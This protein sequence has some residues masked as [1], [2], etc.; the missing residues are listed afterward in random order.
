MDIFGNDKEKRLSELQLQPLL[1]SPISNSTC[2][3]EGTFIGVSFHE[4]ELTELLC[5]LGPIVKIESNYGSMISP[6]YI[7]IDK[8]KV[9]NRGRKKKLKPKKH[10][11]IQGDG[12]KFNSCIQFCI[13]GRATREKSQVEDKYSRLAKPLPPKIV[14]SQ[15]GDIEIKME[16][17]I[18][19]YKFKLFRTGVFQV[20]G[21][22]TEDMSDI[23]APLNALEKYLNF[24][25]TSPIKR[26]ILFSVMRNYKFKL[27]NGC[28][29]LRQLHN[30]CIERFIKLSTINMDDLEKFILLP[31][32]KNNNMP[33][34]R[35]EDNWSSIIDMTYNQLS[36]STPE[37]FE[38][39]VMEMFEYL[40]MSIN[41]HNIYVDKDKLM[42]WIVEA[43]F[44]IYY[45][46]FINYMKI[47]RDCYLQVS[48]E[49]SLKILKLLLRNPIGEL[50]KNIIKHPDNELADI[51][52]DQEKY[53]GL[54][55]YVK[56]PIP[57]KLD[58]C[59]TIK[60]F[61]SGK[62]NIDGANNMTE[63]T[64][65]YWWLNNLLGSNPLFIFDE[66]KFHNE[67]DDEFSESE[68]ELV[69]SSNTEHNT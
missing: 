48:D 26:G 30:Y 12:S 54:L 14:S 16:Q 3:A 67:T 13:L 60:I 61:K 2:C 69:G 57:S 22:L 20:P 38:I 58:K 64:Y 63:A 19:E 5:P 39:D 56:T 59:T 28:I 47:L 43:K 55:I 52:Y 31:I 1:F 24:I 33:H 4:Q 36:K 8:K 29:D 65:I 53:P 11:K 46:K 68:E 6:K 18:K 49:S 15:T 35:D 40:E 34:P 41:P 45:V 10:R 32:F 37:E 9:S 27:M 7:N 17:I 25:S 51:K 21:V 66:N 62:I 42:T 23:R 50:K 44:P